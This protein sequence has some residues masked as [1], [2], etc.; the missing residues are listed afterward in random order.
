[1][2]QLFYHP[3]LF[4]R[5]FPGG[6]SGKEPACQCR[7]HKAVG[8]IP[9]SQRSPGCPEVRWPEVRGKQAAPLRSGGSSRQRK[10]QG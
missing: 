10:E 3:T 4:K 9:G 1:M 6:T 5:G 8:S 7:R 2:I